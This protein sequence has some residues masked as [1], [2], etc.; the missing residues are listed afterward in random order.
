MKKDGVEAM[1]VIKEWKNRRGKREE[2]G[3]VE[4]VLDDSL[5]WMVWRKVDA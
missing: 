1:E 5:G 4:G 3:G 2:Y